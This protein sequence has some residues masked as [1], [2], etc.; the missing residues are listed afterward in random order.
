MTA[1][2]A[3]TL[4]QIY[5]RLRQTYRPDKRASD[6]AMGVA[7]GA[8]YR[9]CSFWV[10]AGLIGLGVSAN[11]V[12]YARYAA[13]AA[14]V[15]C[16]TS[17]TAWGMLAG[18]LCHTGHYFLDFVDGNIAR[19]HGRPTRY[20]ALLDGMADRLGYI[21]PP[22]AIGVGLYRRPD[23]LLL[24][25]PV[26]PPWLPLLLGAVTTF[27][28]VL[29]LHWVPGRWWEFLGLL[30]GERTSSSCVVSPGVCP[31]APRAGPPSAVARRLE[32]VFSNVAHVLETAIVVLAA[33][34]AISAFLGF[35][36][37]YYASSRVWKAADKL[38]G[39]SRPVLG[40]R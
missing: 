29:L 28:T 15:L 6:F 21:L 23:T 3:P 37:A 27:G 40:T 36:F 7:V 5:Y 26:V 10:S 30:R 34:D 2:T 24:A 14:E 32:W 19:Y 11:Q 38:V 8:V 12:T 39:A 16:F 22:L 4:R 9:P 33:C 31:A 17:G 18:S 35:R 1:K 20:G 13:I 25:L